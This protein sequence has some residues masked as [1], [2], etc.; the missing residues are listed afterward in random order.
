MSN[1]DLWSGSSFQAL[2]N[3]LK[4]DTF[5]FDSI[6]DSSGNEALNWIISLL[7]AK[8]FPDSKQH[9]SL[10]EVLC[11]SQSDE[12]A[13]Q[14]YIILNEV[15][16]TLSSL[17]LMI[18]TL[19]SNINLSWEFCVNIIEQYFEPDLEKRKNYPLAVKHIIH[20][21]KKIWGGNP[22]AIALATKSLDFRAHIKLFLRKLLNTIMDPPNDFSSTMSLLYKIFD[23]IFYVFYGTHH[24]F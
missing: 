16:L 3:L 22:E 6:K 13:L 1:L 4:I 14:T 15:L 8:R 18:Q 24:L 2:I 20:Y 19:I 5:S 23:T 17:G 7:R 10:I 21:W 11:N 9:E 12:Q